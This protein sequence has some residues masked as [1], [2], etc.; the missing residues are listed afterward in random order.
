[1]DRFGGILQ[2]VDL[3]GQQAKSI[4]RGVT[5]EFSLT[6]C[7]NRV[8]WDSRRI[9]QKNDSKNAVWTESFDG[10]EIAGSQIWGM[11]LVFGGR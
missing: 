7:F 8:N 11:G 10:V 1:M 5:G 6:T 2:K 3:F 9:C 4:P